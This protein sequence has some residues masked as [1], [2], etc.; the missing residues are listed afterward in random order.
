MGQYFLFS[1]EKLKHLSINIDVMDNYKIY[2]YHKVIKHFN[3]IC[4]I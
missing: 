3:Y 2:N 4:I 1:N